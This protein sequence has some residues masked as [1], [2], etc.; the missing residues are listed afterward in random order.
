M[1]AARGSPAIAGCRFQDAIYCPACIGRALAA[2]PRY[3]GRAL[4][5][6]IVIDAEDDLCEIAA[7]SG[8]TAR[9]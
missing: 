6:G 2:D 9:G 3:D 7:D 8:L 5:R 4:A 1:A